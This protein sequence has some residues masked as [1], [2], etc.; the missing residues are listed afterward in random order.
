[1]KTLVRL[2]VFSMAVGFSIP[3]FAEE[4]AAPAAPAVSAEEQAKMAEVQKR[5]TP[6][7]EQKVLEAMAGKWTY[8]GTFWMPDGKSQES[9]GTSTS[10]MIYGGRFL[11]ETVIGTWMGQP[12]EGV[13]ITGYDNVKGE[14]TSIWYDNMAT[15]IM[16]SAGSFDAATKTLKLGGTASCP[17]TGIKD[18]PMRSETVIT[19]N[20]THTMTSYMTM[21]GKESKGME[22]VSTRVA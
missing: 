14:Y 8:K 12:F 13:G 21:D 6:G 10:E 18:M 3:A 9:T 7:A 1:M 11:K 20:S 5:M 2:F 15:S 4:A 22:I 16:T 17:M 19:D